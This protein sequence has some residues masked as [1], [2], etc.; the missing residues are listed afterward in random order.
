MNLE[1]KIIEDLQSSMKRKDTEKVQALR[2]I[3][4]AIK[5]TKADPVMGHNRDKSQELP[6]AEVLQLISREVKMRKDSVDAFRNA[7]RTDL[8]K[9]EEEAISFLETYLPQ[10]L[11]D[12]ELQKLIM[13]TIAEAGAKTP[14]DLGKVMSLIMNKIKGRADGKTVNIMIRDILSTM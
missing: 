8:V 3:L 10:K 13:E 5:K 4:A 11:S 9:E 6:D 14:Q 2:M 12:E 1:R 7:G